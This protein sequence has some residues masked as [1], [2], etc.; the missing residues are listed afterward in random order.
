MDTAKQLIIEVGKQAR[1]VELSRPKT[2]TE[3]WQMFRGNPGVMPVLT[4][5]GNVCWATF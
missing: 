4:M 3:I 1:A 5:S 2:I